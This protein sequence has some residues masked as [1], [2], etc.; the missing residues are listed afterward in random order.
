M[1]NKK[2]T[3]I[4]SCDYIYARGLGRLKLDVKNRS[5]SRIFTDCKSDRKIANSCII[6][7]MHHRCTREPRHRTDVCQFSINTT[8]FGEPERPALVCTERTLIFFYLS[9][10]FFSR[11]V[12][13]P[14][15]A[16]KL[17]VAPR[18][19]SLHL[20]RIKQQQK[21]IFLNSRLHLKCFSKSP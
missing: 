19:R 11:A 14:I 21:A 6:K 15:C 5:D 4:H 17:N 16:D 13:S 1:A 10:S 8:I 3:Y 7:K 2:Y 12:A 9:L 18:M 20:L